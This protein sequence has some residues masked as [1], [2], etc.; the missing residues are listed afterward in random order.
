MDESIKLMKGDCLELMG[1][2]S[3]ASV[4]LLLV[5]LPYGTTQCKWDQII[6]L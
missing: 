3:D 1:D 4:D 2:I 6:P 5:D